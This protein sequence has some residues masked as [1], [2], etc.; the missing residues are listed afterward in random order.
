M[1][2]TVLRELLQETMAG[3]EPPIGRPMV[4]G[5]VRGARRA[6]RRRLAAGITAAAA[7]IPALAIGLPAVAGALAP[8]TPVR[9]IPVQPLAGG[10]PVKKTTHHAAA[11]VTTFMFV[12]PRRLANH[13]DVNPVPITIQSLGQLLIDDLPAHAGMSQIEAS[14]N[15]NPSATYR[16][17]DAWFNDVTTPIGSGT[18]QA[19]NMLAGSKAIDFGCPP[20]KDPLCR[21]YSLP[22]GV[23]VVEM[24]SQ[25]VVQSTRT[26]FVQLNVDVFRPGV[27][28]LSIF[29]SD[30]AMAAG[31]PITRGMPLTMRQMLKIALDSRWQFTISQAFVTAASGLHVAPLDMSG[32]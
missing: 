11:P 9:R 24:Y 13:A 25:G 29:E 27:A 20:S 19:D 21:L 31:S 26:P 32:S 4:G 15:V 17:A 8:A 2:E 28:E 22:G 18:V 1:N 7:I 16:T 5:A 23:K 6:R 12:R 14:V 30:G 10:P 3:D